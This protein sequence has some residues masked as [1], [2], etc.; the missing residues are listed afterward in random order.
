MGW[1]YG[2]TSR[3]MYV[4]LVAF[5]GAI[6]RFGHWNPEICIKI[7]RLCESSYIYWSIRKMWQGEWRTRLTLCDMIQGFTKHCGLRICKHGSFKVWATETRRISRITCSNFAVQIFDSYWIMYAQVP[8]WSR[9]DNEVL[10]MEDA[11]LFN[12]L[13]ISYKMKDRSL[14]AWI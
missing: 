5:I 12:L 9:P 3:R 10:G 13:R 7:L 1:W 14:L 4:K 8:S 6:D 2:S 11:A